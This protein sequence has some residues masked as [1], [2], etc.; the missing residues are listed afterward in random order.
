MFKSER[1]FYV[2]F[3]CVSCPYACCILFLLHSYI[4]S[5]SLSLS[6]SLPADAHPCLLCYFFSLLFHLTQN[7]RAARIELEQRKEE[8]FRQL[9]EKSERDHQESME[10]MTTEINRAHQRRLQSLSVA[11]AE[12]KKMEVYLLF[13]SLLFF[14]FLSFFLSSSFVPSLSNARTSPYK[15]HPHPTT[16]TQ[17]PSLTHS[18]NNHNHNFFFFFSSIPT[19]GRV[20]QSWSA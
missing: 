9:A 17:H 20:S 10:A 5:L 19:T 6:V 4:L 8:T 3:F 2:I 14:F 11:M 7:I 13:F 1:I 18:D 16:P 12:K 15:P